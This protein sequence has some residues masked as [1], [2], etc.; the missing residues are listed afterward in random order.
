[1]QSNSLCAFH[2]VTQ[3]KIR[4]RAAP[5]SRNSLQITDKSHFSTARR[6]CI[7]RTMPWQDV[8]PSVRLSFTRRYCDETVTYIIK[9][10][11]QSDC[12]T[13]L[14]FLYQTVWQHS[15]RDSPNG[16]VECKGA[17]TINRDFRQIS[18]FI[19]EII[20]K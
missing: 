19:S 13:I 18:R 5:R 9:L 4:N 12:H 16:G 7:A 2:N 11:T 8:C 10:F 17:M 6:V 14:V 15:H 20:K 1:M 3:S